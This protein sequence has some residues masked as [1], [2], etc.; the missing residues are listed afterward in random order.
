M[1]PEGFG[2][3]GFQLA[4]FGDLMAEA[5]RLQMMSDL[6]SLVGRQAGGLVAGVDEAGRGCLAGPVVAAAY[7][8]RPG[9]LVAGVDDSK[10]VGPERRERLAVDLR[11]AGWWSVAAVSAETIDRI[12]ILEATKLAMR[13]ALGSLEVEPAAI[14]TDAVRLAVSFSGRRCQ[15]LP[16]VRGDRIS[17]AIAAA[18]VL[19]KVERDR[20]M[21]ALDPLYPGYDLA[22][23]KGYGSAD[24]RAALQEVGPSPVHRLTFRSVVPRLGEEAA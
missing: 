18:S 24:H 14:L 6:E 23:N 22:G 9:F 5:F 19:A 21:A 11:R 10:R 8:P 15:A 17:Y 12:N 16:L 2:E 20:Q 4:S 13:R 3:R 1:R 7:V